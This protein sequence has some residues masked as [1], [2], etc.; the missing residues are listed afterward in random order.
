MTR[1]P[2]TYARVRLFCLWLC[3]VAVGGCS[4][5]TIGGTSGPLAPQ[6]EAIER[7][8]MHLAKLPHAAGECIVAN[9]Q[10]AG[11]AAQLVPLYGLES[12]AVT[13][14]DRVAGEQLAVFSLTRNDNGA[15]AETTTWSGVSGRQELLRKLTQGC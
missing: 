14:T 12:V 4:G 2:Q 5:W 6:T 7:S 15:H 10:Q 8:S 1:P 3:V 9:A 11:A 13:V